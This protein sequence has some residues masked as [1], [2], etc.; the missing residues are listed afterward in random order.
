[1]E[2]KLRTE[3]EEKLRD[4]AKQKGMT[5]EELVI[6]LVRKALLSETESTESNL[7]GYSESPKDGA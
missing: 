6:E 2:L 3:T 5:P 4:L 7:P 1:M